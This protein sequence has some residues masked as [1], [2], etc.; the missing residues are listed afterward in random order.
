VK[1]RIRNTS[2]ALLFLGCLVTLSSAFNL[3]NRSADRSS[4][5]ASGGDQL[6]SKNKTKDTAAD[7]VDDATIGIKQTSLK[8]MSPLLNFAITSES[9]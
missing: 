7:D 2:A 1:N 8:V 6:K 3:P 5:L 4:R 9:G